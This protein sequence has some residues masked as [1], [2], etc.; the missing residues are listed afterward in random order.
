MIRLS[1]DQF[2]L[3][4]KLSINHL[5]WDTNFFGINVGQVVIEKPFA[6]HKYVT[7]KNYDLIVVEQQNNFE[8]SIIDYYNSYQETKLV[9]QKKNITS[10]SSLNKVKDTDIEL[11]TYEKL[12]NLALL[13]GKY[14]RFC[15]DKKIGESNFKS[16]YKQWVLNSLSK[17]FANKVF[18]IEQENT[19]VGFVTVATKHNYAQI[20]LIA[21]AEQYQGNGYGVQLLNKV[22]YYCAQN[23]ITE[24]RIP[25][26]LK[27]KQACLFY[28]KNGYV[29][30]EEKII[31][32]FWK[33]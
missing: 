13:S 11:I 12:Y 2:L 5:E 14:S 4:M 8:V 16:L 23:R 15:L 31:K 28:K 20:G 29:V 9:F 21:V 10:T 26:Q 3:L 22:E 32:H 17:Q 24:L 25:T 7:N 6:N 1:N 27:N 30:C 33:K 18:Y 19:V